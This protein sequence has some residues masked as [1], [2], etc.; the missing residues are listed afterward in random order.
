MVERLGFEPK[1]MPYQSIMITISS[2]LYG[3]GG[4]H[5]THVLKPLSTKISFLHY[6]LYLDY[7]VQ[8]DDSIPISLYSLMFREGLDYKVVLLN[9]SIQEQAH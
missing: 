9:K 5:R 4:E 1:R 7:K 8:S 3:G 2:S 6:K